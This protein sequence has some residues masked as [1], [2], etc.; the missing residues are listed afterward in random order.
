MATGNVGSGI[1]AQCT[2]W[3]RAPAVSRLRSTQGLVMW[4][5]AYRWYVKGM[6]VVRPAL[7]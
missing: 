6:Q 4:G 2:V 5:A 3:S 7:N 1:T